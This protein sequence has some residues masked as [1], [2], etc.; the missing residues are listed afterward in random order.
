MEQV[1]TQATK[2]NLDREEIIRTASQCAVQYKHM[3]FHCSES[4]IRAVPLALGMSLPTDVIRCA[5]GFFGGG[6]GTGDRCGIIEVGIMLLSYLY[7]RMHPMQSENNMRVLVGRLQDEFRKEI[8]SI[9]CRDIKPAAVARC[10]I[11]MGCEETYAKGA[12]L[13]T[14]II[15]DADKI[16][17]EQN[18]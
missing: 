2:S 9:Y 1:N 14:K 15:L 11:E 3:G 18:R 12:A 6:G 13:V 4:M 10:G 5:C 17:A 16:L 7:A 8:G